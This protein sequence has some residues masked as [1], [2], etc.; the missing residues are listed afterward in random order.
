MAGKTESPWQSFHHD[1]QAIIGDDPTLR[2]VLSSES[3]PFAHEAGVFIPD[4]NELIITSN[5]YLDAGG[6]KK[7]QVSKVALGDHDGEQAIWKEIDYS[8]IVM[9]N[10]GVNYKD[11]VLLCAQ[12][13]MTAPSGLFEASIVPP[14]MVRPVLTNFYGRPFNS[15]NDVVTG[16]DGCIW[17]TDP[18]YGYDQGY[19]PPP[20]LPNQVYRFDPSTN[21]TRAVADGIGRPNGLCFSPD[22]TVLYVT[23]TDLIHAGND[24]DPKRA[25]TM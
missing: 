2:V 14:Y 13:S 24:K 8:D 23:D 3:Y 25:A 16:T 11:G 5:Q 6:T 9:A 4:T 15:V 19:R 1:F 18:M 22:E 12:G 17:F 20:S 10:G 21:S 7:V